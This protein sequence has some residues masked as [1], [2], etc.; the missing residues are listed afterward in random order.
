MSGLLEKKRPQLVSNALAFRFFKTTCQ[1]VICG[2]KFT[3]TL[4][5]PNG[6][7]PPRT[8][9]LQASPSVFKLKGLL[10]KIK[11]RVNQK[12]DACKE[13]NRKIQYILGS[14]NPL[15]KGTISKWCFEFGDAP[16]SHYSR[17]FPRRSWSSNW[18]TLTSPDVAPKPPRF[19]E[20]FGFLDDQLRGTTKLVIWGWW[21]K[22]MLE[23]SGFL[24]LRFSGSR[25]FR[26]V[27]LT[28][29]S[30]SLFWY[31]AKNTSHTHVFF[32]CCPCWQQ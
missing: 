25:H 24:L 6:N 28:I 32:C 14:Q 26:L 17:F 11:N 31:P 20:D 30:R 12:N 13:C 5:V 7:F 23:V 2:N 1:T 10:Y 19:W 8:A 4:L 15:K 29:S 27:K 16:G 21:L 22:I 9:E 3:T 18:W